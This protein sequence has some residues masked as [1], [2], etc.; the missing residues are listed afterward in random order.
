MATTSGFEEAA[1]AAGRNRRYL[2]ALFV[3]HL[4][5]SVEPAMRTVVGC[6]C[7][8][9]R[10][11]TEPRFQGHIPRATVPGTGD[12]VVQVDY[13]SPQ[14]PFRKWHSPHRSLLLTHIT[15][16]GGRRCSQLPEQ[17]RIHN[18]FPGVVG[19]LTPPCHLCTTT[20][21]AGVFPCT[22]DARRLC[23]WPTGTPH[24]DRTNRHHA[25]RLMKRHSSRRYRTNP[26]RVGGPTVVSSRNNL[27]AVLL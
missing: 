8:E 5:G 14:T 1:A 12:S 3:R 18:D 9:R 26:H 15:S 20:E 11:V 13:Y 6:A 25:R 2:V 27:D 24:T 19:L 10:V 21:H 23:T 4:H 7:H 17:P 22:V 16:N